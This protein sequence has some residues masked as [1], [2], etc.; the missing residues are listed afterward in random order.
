MCTDPQKPPKNPPKMGYFLCGK[1][2]KNPPFLTKTPYFGDF[3]DF[4]QFWGF[5][6]ILRNRLDSAGPEKSPSRRLPAM[7]EE[8]S[9]QRA[10]VWRRHTRFRAE[11]SN[12]TPSGGVSQELI[13]FIY[14]AYGD[15]TQ[16][17]PVQ[18]AVW[19][20]QEYTTVYF[21]NASGCL[22][23]EGASA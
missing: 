23:S 3:P 18:A 20:V 12:F 14:Q 15:G 13:T 19:K 21:L 7:Q 10:C 8:R 22:L 2:P 4:G 5:W 11:L 6:P 16:D 9:K 17:F 1:P